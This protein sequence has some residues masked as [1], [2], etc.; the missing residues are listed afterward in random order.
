MEQAAPDWAETNN[1]KE[2]LLNSPL[3][4]QAEDPEKDFR[5]RNHHFTTLPVKDIL[6]LCMSDL[7]IKNVDLASSLGY[8]MPNVIA[9]MKSGSMKLPASKAVD[10]ARLLNLDPAFLLGKVIGENDADLWE[11]I[12]KTFG[13]SIVSA[14][15]MA[16]ISFVRERLEGHDVDL[17]N[18][19][20][21]TQV[22]NPLLK[23]T[24]NRERRLT[25]AALARFAKLATPDP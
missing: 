14:N 16:L 13:Q 4:N 11:V 22:I 17:T 1:A 9:M 5:S 7:G 6:K 23:A 19:I 25:A 3:L 8:K 20:E 2:V 15:E 10:C 12:S 21:F 24:A 18:D